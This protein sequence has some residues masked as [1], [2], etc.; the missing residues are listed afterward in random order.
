M[1][2]KKDSVE[3]KQ[4]EKV[5]D[6]EENSVDEKQSDDENEGEEEREEEEESE[7]E[8]EEDGE[9]DEKVDVVIKDEE[10]FND[11]ATARN[12]PTGKSETGEEIKIEEVSDEED[13]KIDGVKQE[14]DRDIKQEGGKKKRNRNKNK[15][16][17]EYGVAR[18]IDFRD[19]KTV[20]NFEFPKST[21]AYIHR[22]GRTA[23]GDQ[24]GLAISLIGPYEEEYLAKVERKRNKQI[25]D[26]G[27]Q[28]K[29]AEPF[30][31]RCEDA[32]KSVGM[33]TVEKARKKAITNVLMASKK[34]KQH[35]KD[36]KAESILVRKL[37]TKSLLPKLTK[38]K[39]MYKNIPNYLLPADIVEDI[40][41]RSAPPVQS[42]R[43]WEKMKKR[44]SA[45]P[46]LGK[47]R[48]KT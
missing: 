47:K 10:E 31:Y 25:K 27:F 11:V 19:V 43:A 5:E 32:Y 29:A 28:I 9:S 26:F 14:E 12:K 46:V 3:I 36:N 42:N 34:L 35:W 22:V 30:R 6:D 4:V 20:I 48:R 8:D 33:N 1:W 7:G 17:G 45:D 21:K 13:V 18:G 38:D 40:N 16:D 39:T 15:K 2:T 23:R 44:K 37:H 41:A 24:S